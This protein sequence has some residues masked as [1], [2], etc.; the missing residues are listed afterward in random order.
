MLAAHANNGAPSDLPH[1]WRQANLPCVPL[2]HVQRRALTLRLPSQIQ[3]NPDGYHRPCLNCAGQ[4]ICTL[5]VTW[6]Y[7]CPCEWG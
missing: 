3:P 4:Q 7:P 1:E 6:C 5:E 2:R